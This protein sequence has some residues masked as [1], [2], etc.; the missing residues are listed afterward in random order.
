[1]S[2]TVAGFDRRK[3]IV[4]PRARAAP[5]RTVR[6]VTRSPVMTGRAL[7]PA[8]QPPPRWRAISAAS[9]DGKSV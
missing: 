5:A 1:V 4:V 2:R 6:L 7:P 9:A 3:T 8:R